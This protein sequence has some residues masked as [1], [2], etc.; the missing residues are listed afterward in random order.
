M[1]FGPLT[2]CFAQKEYENFE[3]LNNG[4]DIRQG[5]ITYSFFSVVPDVELKGEQIGIVDGDKTH[6][7]YSSDE[8]IIE[9]HDMIMSIYILYKADTVMEIPSELQFQEDIMIKNS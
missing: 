2:S 4:A 6:K 7:I 1:M 5:D 9:Y 3:E 8:W